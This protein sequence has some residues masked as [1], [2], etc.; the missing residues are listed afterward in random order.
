MGFGRTTLRF[1][2]AHDLYKELTHFCYWN[3]LGEAGAAKRNGYWI[4]PGFLSESLSTLP[5]SL[6]LYSPPLLLARVAHVFV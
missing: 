6:P 2:F 4:S 3:A 5:L 1:P